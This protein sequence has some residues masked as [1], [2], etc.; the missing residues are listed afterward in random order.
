MS[1]GVGLR[2]ISDLALLWL[3]HRPA[4]MAPIRLLAC[5]PLYA[6]GEAL[7][8]QKKKK[9]KGQEKQDYKG[10]QR[11]LGVV[12]GVFIFLIR[13]INSYTCMYM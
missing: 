10:V 8:R 13:V 9:K 4:A 1:C 5:E 12:M 6:V 2:F 3:W 7:K 11:S